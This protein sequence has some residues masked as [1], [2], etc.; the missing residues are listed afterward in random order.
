METTIV[1]EP[2][3]CG[4]KA[5][6]TTREFDLLVAQMR[7]YDIGQQGILRLAVQRFLA[8][9]ETA[10]GEAKAYR[11]RFGRKGGVQQP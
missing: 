10:I 2:K 1:R 5:R 3:P 4:L 9:P 8:L 7:Y 6:V 11:E